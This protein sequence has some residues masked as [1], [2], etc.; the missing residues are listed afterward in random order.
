MIPPDW[1]RPLVDAAR[2]AGAGALSRHTRPDGV[3]GR[4]SAVLMLFGES[5]ITGPDVLLIERA[6]TL[7]SHAGQP[8]FPGGAVDPDDDGPVAAA[9]RE[10]A[11]ETGLDTSG[12][13]VLEVMAPLWLPPSGYVVTP[14]LAWW[15][16]PSA[17]GV[18][19]PEEVASVHRV[20]LADLVDP[21]NRLRVRHPSGYIGP[22]FAVKGLIV[23]GFTAGILAALLDAAGLAKPWDSSR[24]EPMPS[25]VRLR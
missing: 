20:A 3:D 5:E 11:E 4:E 12:V 24:V 9:L 15:R 1:L 18:M 21:A 8:A 19:D 23:W 25:G 13:E 17:V 7:R 6:H 22:A 2:Q 10:A 16:E 14:V